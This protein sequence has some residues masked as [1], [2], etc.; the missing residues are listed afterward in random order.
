MEA[1]SIDRKSFQVTDNGVLLGEIIY[2]NIQF[3]TA[4]IKCT[5]S[6]TYQIKPNGLFQS[7]ISLTQNDVP[8]ASLSLSWN[9]KIVITFQS[10]EEYVVLLNN[11][12]SNK[13]ILENKN[14]EKLM[15][16]ESKFNWRDFQYRY[17]ITYNIT[18]NT[19]PHDTLLLLLAVYSVNFFIATLSGA[20]AGMM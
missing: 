12:F 2:E 6:E 7:S 9:G 3:I 20:N 13:Y 14:K 17:D 18:D 10:G 15:L 5:D 11:I 1:I 19:K 16:L 8:I 4:E